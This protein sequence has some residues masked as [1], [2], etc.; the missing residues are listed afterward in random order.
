VTDPTFV[1][2]LRAFATV[3]YDLGRDRAAAEAEAVENAKLADA[4]RADLTATRTRLSEALTLIDSL[5]SDGLIREVAGVAG[6]LQ[7]ALDN[8]DR[9]VLALV[10]AA[11]VERLR[12]LVGG[13]DRIE[14]K[15]S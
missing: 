11:Q 1:D 6:I 5:R 3:A 12:A 7:A 13:R 4:L 2:L 14:A 8:P 10:A 15:P 9:K